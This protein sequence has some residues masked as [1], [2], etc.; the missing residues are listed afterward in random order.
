LQK[1]PACPLPNPRNLVIEWD[2]AEAEVEQ[3]CRDLGVVRADPEEYV[4]KYGAELK[5]SH[6][7]PQLCQE[8]SCGCQKRQPTPRPPTP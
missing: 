2:A 6:E 4:R 7:I 3:V 5:Q 1:A 8:S